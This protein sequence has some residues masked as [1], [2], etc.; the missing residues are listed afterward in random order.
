M[1]LKT[2]SVQILTSYFNSDE[3]I[4]NLSVYNELTSFVKYIST[5]FP[6]RMLEKQSH[7]EPTLSVHNCQSEKWIFKI[8]RNITAK[9]DV[10]LLK[11]YCKSPLFPVK[12]E[13]CV[14]NIM[15]KITNLNNLGCT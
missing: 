3:S 14:K 1:L 10:F 12:D 9:M 11:K 2:K 6:G 7:Q 8:F 15:Y 5:S 4:Q 13:N